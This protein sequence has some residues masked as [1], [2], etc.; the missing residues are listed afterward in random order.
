LSIKQNKTLRL[1][2]STYFVKKIS[3]ILFLV[4]GLTMHLLAQDFK[5]PITGRVTKDGKKLE[6]AIVTVIKNGV[7]VQQL[8]TSGNGKFDLVLDANA[9]YI[10]SF[11][12]AG[13]I[14]KRLSFSTR[15]VPPERAKEGFAGLDVGEIGIFEDLPGSN[16]NAILQ[17]PVGKFAYF[18]SEGDFNYDEAY[19]RSIQSQLAQIKAAEEEAKKK[20]EELLKNYN[21]AIAKGDKAMAAKDYNAAKAAYNEALSYKEDNYP[22]Q[23]IAEADKLLAQSLAD[24]EAKKKAEE[25]AKKKAE[26]E[27]KYNAAIKKGDEAFSKK[28]WN[29]AKTAY[30]EALGLKSNEK[31]P[32]DQLAAIEKAIADELAAKKKAE[33]EAKAKAELE[34]KYNAAIKK[35]DEAFSKKDWN[36]AKTAYNEA[37]GL[38]SNEKYPKDQLA[39][40]EKAIA[41]ELAAKKKAEEEAKRKAEEEA[42]RKAEEEAKRKAE[43]EAKRKAE[44]EAK[45]KA[46]EEAKRKAE[47]EAKRKAEEEAKR[48][49]EEEAKRKAEEE[50]KRKAEEEAKRKAE[51]EAKRKAEEEAKRKAEEEAKRKAEEEAKRKAEEEAKRKAEEEAKRKAEEEAKRKAEEEAKRKAEE[52]AKRK[53]EEE[54]K[55]KAEEEAKRKAEEEA[56]RKAEEEA[57]RKAEEEAKRKAEEE[58]KRKAE[59]EAKLK[60]EEEAKRKAEEEAKR[61]AEEEAKRKAEEEAKRKAEEEAKRKAEEEAKRKA[62]EEAKRK[63]EEEAKR[64]AEEEAKRKAEEEAKRK[65][66]EEAKRKAEEE[67]K[68]KAEEEAKRKA[69]EEAKRKAEEEA[70][71]KAEEEAKRKAEEEAKRK[72]EEEAKRKAEEEA[73]RKAEEEAKRK[74]EEE[75][76]RKAEEEAKRKAEEEAKRKAEEE[77]KRK[78][79]EEAKRKAEEEAKAKALAEAE[80]KRKAE[81]EARLAKESEINAKY[82]AA[83]KKGDDAFGFKEYNA[84]KQAYKDALLIK[85]N[86]VYPKNKIDEI[87]KILAEIAAN[88]SKQKELTAKYNS[89]ISKGDNAFFAKDFATAKL[90]YNEAL[91]YKPQE[92]Y[93]K[94]KLDEIEKILSAELK[95]KENEQRYKTAISNGDKLFNTKEYTKSKGFYNEALTYKPNDPYATQKISQI[96]KIISD[97]AKASQPKTQVVEPPKPVEKPKFAVDAT[98]KVAFLSELAQKYPEG[99]TEELYTDDPMKKITRRIVVR[100]KKATEYTKVEYKF[101]AVYYFMNGNTPIT[102]QKWNQDTK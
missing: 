61:K 11:T 39:A 79:E 27:A 76:K 98:D 7:Q 69:E 72:A 47:E 78:A 90:A 68:R 24:A 13:Y 83:I 17:Q 25:E 88:E 100:D 16:I 42:K 75:A 9:D 26:L 58:A 33:E 87:D 30:N 91:N 52:E 36:A 18:P 80:A 65:A 67:A 15:G 55:R 37:L 40:I 48:K 5:L 94:Q 21:A 51:E 50:A 92:Q 60:A 10:I 62:E 32:K 53:A 82:N 57:K 73:K 86:E 20:A 64:K 81:E 3:L 59:E 71:R 46:E 84:A 54:A 56:K 22:K 4:F 29:A 101:G 28:D 35:G 66:E 6:G 43:E 19:T 74:A 102:E 85:P 70:K 44:E 63:A 97:L 1:I 45:R 93:P 2:N 96:D 8:T 31:Y 89:A 14:T 41:D 12:K 99:V 49:A 34:A 77:A 38:K 23:K 95:A